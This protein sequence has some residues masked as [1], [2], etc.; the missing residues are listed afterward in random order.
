VADTAESVPK[1]EGGNQSAATLRQPMKVTVAPAPTKNR[2]VMSTF[3][4]AAMPIASEP[5]PMTALPVATTRRTPKLSIKSPA[6]IMKPA[7]A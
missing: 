3:C 7:Y 2:P 5:S 4:E 1:W 6:G